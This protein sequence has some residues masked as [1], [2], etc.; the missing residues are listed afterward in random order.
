MFLQ[1]FK[2]FKIVTFLDIAINGGL[3]LVWLR[4]P[5]M[6]GFIKLKFGTVMTLIVFAGFEV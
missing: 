6:R 1:C 5:G 2:R 3:S 4:K